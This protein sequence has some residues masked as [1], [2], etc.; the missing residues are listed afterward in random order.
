MRREKLFFLVLVVLAVGSAAAWALVPS[1]LRRSERAEVGRLAGANPPQR[2]K[3]ANLRDVSFTVSWVTSGSQQCFVRYG[4]APGKLDSKA[5]DERGASYAGT[6]HYVVLGNL[7]PNTGYYFD[8]ICGGVAYDSGGSPYRMTTGPPLGIPPPGGTIFGQV[9]K[10][11]GKSPAEG[12]ILYARLQ[13]ADGR[14]ASGASA[15][16]SYLIHRQDEGYWILDLNSARQRSGEISVGA[17][18]DYSPA[19]K[20]ELYAEGGEDGSVTKVVDAGTSLPIAA[21]TL[22]KAMPTPRSTPVATATPTFVPMPSP[23]A[24]GAPSPTQTP[25]PSPT[26][27]SPPA[28]PTPGPLP[29]ATP[30]PQPM[31]SPSPT[32]PPTP[33][34]TTYV[35]Q[36]GDTLEGIAWRFGVAE[37]SIIRVNNLPNPDLIRVGQRLLI[38]GIAQPTPTPAPTIYV[39]KWGDTLASI[40]ARFGITIEALAQA[41][42]L[43]VSSWVYA[44]QRLVIPAPQRELSPYTVQFGDT[45][46]GIATRFGSTTWAIMEANNLPNPNLIYVGQVLIIPR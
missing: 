24:T 20:L 30:S 28:T 11:D 2:L 10:A 36:P 26:P 39:V 44:G 42:S 14:G 33:A 43:W 22:G 41:N 18:F 21:L 7:L 38:P 6:T 45:L 17:Y 1:R 13:D 23:I 34:A 25:I 35:V 5:E 40:A 16:L 8:L 37:E 3:V 29:L 19:D 46:E 4:G 32:L 15:E 9:L 27:T 31:P 12:V